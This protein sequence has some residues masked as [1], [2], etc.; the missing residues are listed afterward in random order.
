[1][2]IALHMTINPLQ[3]FESNSLQYVAK[4]NAIWP[5]LFFT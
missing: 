2:D 4:V 1:M 5:S 3:Q